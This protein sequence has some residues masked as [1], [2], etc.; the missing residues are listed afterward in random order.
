MPLNAKNC[1]VD[2]RLYEEQTGQ[3]V[4]AEPAKLKAVLYEAEAQIELAA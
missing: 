4:Q 1:P 3:K 2:S